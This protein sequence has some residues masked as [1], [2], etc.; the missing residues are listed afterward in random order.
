MKR[1]RLPL[2]TFAVACLSCGLTGAALY[3]A[4]EKVPP[5]LLLPA[6][7][8]CTDSKPIEVGGKPT[9]FATCA[10]G[11]RHRPEAVACPYVPRPLSDFESPPGTDFSGSCKQDTDCREKPNGSCDVVL[12]IYKLDCHYGCAQ[13]SDCGKN[14][15]CECKSPAG[16]CVPTQCRTDGDCR[17]GAVCGEYWPN[18]GCFLE[19]AYA[20]QTP[21]D[22]CASDEQCKGRHG[23]FCSKDGAGPRVCKP[24]SCMY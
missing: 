2:N 7:I 15:I 16:R 17:D 9:G 22:S 1:L 10:N 6:A 8:R 11:L 18:P 23:A 13:D 21:L 20:C 3:G 24:M 14:E 5:G 4:P 19:V 12:P